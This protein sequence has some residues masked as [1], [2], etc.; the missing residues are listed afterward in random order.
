MAKEASSLLHKLMFVL[1]GMLLL[2]LL[3]RMMIMKLLLLLQ[4]LLIF[5]RVLDAMQPPVSSS[6]SACG[7]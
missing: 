5:L 2:L 6:A 3:L 1:E 4:L 7:K